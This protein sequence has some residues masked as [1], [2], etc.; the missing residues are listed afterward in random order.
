MVLLDVRAD[1]M[2]TSNESWKECVEWLTRCDVLRRDHKTN[3]P[4]ASVIDLANTLRDG[5]LLCNLLNV[6]DPGCIDLKDVNQKPQL[7]QFLCLRN[8]KTF[9]QTCHDIFGLKENDLFEPSMLFELNDF[10]KVLNT[11]SKLSNC[12]KVQRKQIIANG[13]GVAGPPVWEHGDRGWMHFTI[14]CPQFVDR[15]EELYEELCYVTFSSVPPEECITNSRVCPLMSSNQFWLGNLE[16]QVGSIEVLVSAVLKIGYYHCWSLHSLMSSS[17]YLGAIDDDV[18][19]CVRDEEV[20]YCAYYARINEVYEDLCSIVSRAEPEMLQHC[21]SQDPSVNNHSLEKRD[22]VI[23]ELVETEKNYVDVLATVQRSFMRPLSSFIREEDMKAIFSGMKELSEIHSGFHSH[24]RKAVAP[25]SSTRLSDVFINWREKFLIYGEYC[26]HLTSAQE[27]IQDLCSRNEVVNQQVIKCQ[28]E[29]NGGK[30]KLRD[31]LSVPMQ[32]IL[33]YHLLLDKLIQETQPSQEHQ[34]ASLELQGVPFRVKITKELVWSYRNHE[35][36]RGLERAKEAMVDVAQYINEVKRDSDTLAIMSSIQVTVVRGQNNT[37]VTCVFVPQDSIS[38]LDMPENTELKDYGRLLKD[39]E[40]KIKAHDDQKIKTRYIFVFDQVIIMCKSLRVYQVSLLHLQ[41]ETYSYRESLRLQEYKIEDVHTRRTLRTDARWSYQFYLVR[42]SERTAYTLYAR[43]EDN[44]RKWMKVYCYVSCPRDN[45]EPSVCRNTTHT[46]KM[47]T[48]EQ[49][50][51]CHHCSKFL[52]G[53]ILQQIP[54]GY[55]T[56]GMYLQATTCHHCS[57]FLK[58]I[59]LQGYLCGE[60]SIAVHKQCI[61]FSGRC[62]RSGAPPEPPPRPP[63]LD[64]PPIL[65][66]DP[67]L[68]DHLWFVGE[69][70]R[71]RASA[72]L[73]RHMDGTYLLRVR[74]QGATHPNETIYALSLKTDDRVKHMKV[75]ERTMEGVPH[76]FLSESRFFRS[77]TDLIGCYEHSSLGENFVG[78][79]VTLKWPFRRIIAIAE[80]DFNP[81]ES[82]QLPLRKGCQVIVL[83]K[84][85]DYKGWWKGKVQDRVGFFPKDYVREVSETD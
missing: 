39:G 40:L 19:C 11:L 43:T 53:I 50:T 18:S 46:F 85:G 55:Y 13:C 42:K 12:V 83:S 61:E 5:V 65:W 84:E 78:L 22:Y 63:R 52:K 4:E 71:D 66:P 17:L 75:Y 24:L 6:L 2:A 9:L 51:T 76:Y 37:L 48:F 26:A 82:N 54:Q 67:S 31:I 21:V 59:I 32:R 1:R 81:S 27:L 56:P 25:N 68:K 69:M 3:W 44:K 16:Q 14:R 57:K 20:E 41:G 74:P 28:E 35:D 33:K 36:Y 79:D 47:N 73:E 62:H 80:F 77:I 29:A 30:F 64:P 34:G 60:C 70:G 7:A 45:L 38:D 8:I 58:G 15:D 10:F 23:K 72:L 49:A